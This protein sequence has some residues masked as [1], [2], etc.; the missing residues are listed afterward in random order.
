MTMMI[1]MIRIAMMVVITIRM[2][3]ADDYDYVPCVMFTMFQV[4]VCVNA[5]SSANFTRHAL[6]SALFRLLLHMSVGIF[7]HICL[8]RSVSLH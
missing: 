2:L 4:S 1:V 8:V 5:L 3:F 7:V 6:S